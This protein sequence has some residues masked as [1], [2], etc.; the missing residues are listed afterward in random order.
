LNIPSPIRKR[1][2]ASLVA[3]SALALGGIASSAIIGSGTAHAATCP[4]PPFTI[5]ATPTTPASCTLTGTATTS[6]LLNLTMPTN[7][8]T[9][10]STGT[11]IVAGTNVAD[12]ATTDLGFTVDDQTAA[13][14]GW[15]VNASYDGWV[16]TTSTGV[17][18]P[19]GMV[20]QFTGSTTATTTGAVPAA[21]PGF[22]LTCTPG[23][24]CND[25]NNTVTGYPLTIT[26]TA[27]NPT[28]P[29]VA[30]YNSAALNATGTGPAG[31]GPVDIGIVTPA[32]SAVNPAAWW[33][34]VPLNTSGGVYTTNVTITIASGPTV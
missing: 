14:A 31:Q 25:P 29:A 7:T 27:I 28:T 12:T 11:P 20:I 4:T 33:V 1:R 8:L 32:E 30:I 13:A 9:W 21:T 17:A 22:T 26:N 34:A 16:N 10:G 3:A 15:N 6:G 18:A 5:S 24:G 2:V 23:P 19:A